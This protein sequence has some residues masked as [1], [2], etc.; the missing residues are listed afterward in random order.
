MKEKIRLN[1]PACSKTRRN[2]FSSESWFLET[3]PKLTP[4]T[5]YYEHI[6]PPHFILKAFKSEVN[7]TSEAMVSRACKE[8]ETNV[9]TL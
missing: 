5:L 2:E 9:T 4:L 6:S 3:E 8:K 7:N 1:T